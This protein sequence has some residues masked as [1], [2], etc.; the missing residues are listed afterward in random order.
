M[1]MS[2]TERA[3]SALTKMSSYLGFEQLHDDAGHC[4]RVYHYVCTETPFAL[5]SAWNTDL[6][7][8]ENNKRTAE[9]LLELSK[10]KLRCI[11][12]LAHTAQD[13]A[14]DR[15]ELALFVACGSDDIDQYKNL[16]LTLGHQFQQ[17]RVCG[18]KHRHLRIY[19]L[20]GSEKKVFNI[21][22]IKPGD[23]KRVLSAM[24]GRDYTHIE[25]GFL[26]A[27]PIFLAGPIYG[28][29]GLFSDV[30]LGL[31]RFPEDA[32]VKY[33]A[34]ETPSQA[35][36][37]IQTDIQGDARTWALSVLKQREKGNILKYEKE[38]A[39]FSTFCEKHNLNASVLLKA[40]AKLQAGVLTANLH[41]AKNSGKPERE[42]RCLQKLQDFC[43]RN[44]LD[45]EVIIRNW[46]EEHQKR[47]RGGYDS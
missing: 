30:P 46:E 35:E 11:S 6:Q 14:S 31:R 36:L 47:L 41:H 17:Q 15:P 12:L 1:V 13:F 39:K 9:L 19:D 8:E 2:M 24:T 20:N 10:S 40:A 4:S 32:K 3:V 27:N 29:V 23:I 37:R 16:A 22:H 45:P 28:S 33:R 38:F 7:V 26:N 21:E 5:F 18:Y 43:L 44:G 25:S 42:A 34:F